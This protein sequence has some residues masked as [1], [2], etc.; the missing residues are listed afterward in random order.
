MK[1]K[2]KRKEKM[3]TSVKGF[4]SN[5]SLVNTE[6]YEMKKYIFHTGLKSLVK[7]GM[8][9]PEFY[10]DYDFLINLGK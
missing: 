6:S 5:L 1:K 7:Q 4:T 3:K 9:E 10:G 2:K 8:S